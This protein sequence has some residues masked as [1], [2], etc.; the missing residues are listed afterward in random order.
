[1]RGTECNVVG[2]HADER[3]AIFLRDDAVPLLEEGGGV[4]HGRCC[5]R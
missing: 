5:Q 2:E 1:M 3:V 4:C